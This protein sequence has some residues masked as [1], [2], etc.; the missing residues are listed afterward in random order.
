MKKRFFALLLA[1][2]GIMLAGVFGY[3]AI[4][5]EITGRTFYYDEHAHH[6]AGRRGGAFVSVLHGS[7]PVEFR[8]GNN[9]LWALSGFGVIVAGIGI[10]FFREID[11][12]E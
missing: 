2:G 8:R 3:V 1:I 10:Y 4:S 9:F 12:Y 11:N 6:D 5:G 7:S